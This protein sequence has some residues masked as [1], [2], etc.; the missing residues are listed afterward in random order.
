MD[1]VDKKILST[2]QDDARVTVAELSERVSLTSSP[3]WRRVKALEEAGF[4]RGYHAE[5]DPR[6]LGYDV[7]AFVNVMLENHRLDLGDSFEVAV[8][9]IPQVVA[10]HNVSGRY[11][12][13]LEVVA[14]DLEA[15][16]EFARNVLRALPGVKE[17]YSS[18]S[19]KSIKRSR[20]IPIPPN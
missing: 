20:S 14:A 19:L 10:C 16:G 12:F 2:L 5:L 3:C 1:K 17:I 18:F 6:Q 8:Q 4:I 9:G 7:T 15:F 13:M 11:D